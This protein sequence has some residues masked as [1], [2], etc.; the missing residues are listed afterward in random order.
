[1]SESRPEPKIVVDSDWKQQAQAEKDR[2]AAAEKAK[3]EKASA[4]KAASPGSGAMAGMGPMGDD[5]H[6]QE[7]MPEAN[8][9]SLLGTLITNALMYMGAFP[10]PQTGRAVVAPEYARFH[11]DL[12]AVLQEKTKNNLTA[13]EAKDIEQSLSELR[14]QF[15]ELMKAVTQMAMKQRAQEGAGGAGGM[16]GM[17]GLDLGGFDPASTSQRLRGG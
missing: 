9:K 11:I 10:D 8:F 6:G 3:A 13:E 1:M 2:L 16:G 14:A 5:E 15:V 17:G 4:A 12:L 7:E